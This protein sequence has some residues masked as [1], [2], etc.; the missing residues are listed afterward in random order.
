MQVCVFP[1]DAL[2][3]QYH[4]HAYRLKGRFMFVNDH[5]LFLLEHVF[6]KNGI[7]L[8]MKCSFLESDLHT[9]SNLLEAHLHSD[10]SIPHIMWSSGFLVLK[11]T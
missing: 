7:W 6:M 4:Q 8:Q 1:N 9:A 11:N 10:L 2:W 5:S 3:E